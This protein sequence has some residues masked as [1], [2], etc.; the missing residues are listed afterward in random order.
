M[1]RRF[2]FTILLG[3]MMICQ[4]GA[5]A[6]TLDVFYKNMP[7]S[8]ES[9]ERA[10]GVLAGFQEEYEISYHIITDPESSELIAQ[11]G[12]PETH[13]PFAIVINGHFS[14]LIEGEKVDFVHFPLFMHGIGR[15]EGNWSMSHLEMV[16]TDNSLLLEENILPVLDESGETECLE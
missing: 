12:L 13:F 1:N 9:L 14:A 15:H 10:E 11:I 7:P 6:G 4:T 16:L 5:L 8:L 2:T 3:I